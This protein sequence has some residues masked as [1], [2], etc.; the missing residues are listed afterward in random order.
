MHGQ[1]NI[2]IKYKEFMYR[3]T[4]NAVHEMYD[5]TGKNWIQWNGNK[6]FK[7]KFGSHARKIFNRFTT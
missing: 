5:Y 2:T 6:S 7:E 1:Q 3:D 4:A